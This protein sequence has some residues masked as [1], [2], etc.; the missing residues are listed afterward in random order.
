M[1][2]D[3]G[4]NEECFR[5]QDGCKEKPLYIHFSFDNWKP[6]P[7]VWDEICSMWTLYRMCPPGKN[8]YYFSF[9]AEEPFVSSDERL[10]GST[11][12]GSHFSKDFIRPPLSSLNYRDVR[13]RKGPLPSPLPHAES[14]LVSGS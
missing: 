9:L 1:W 5:S 11:V 14:C 2:I 3:G 7:M 13:R 8:E 4:W 10:H 12:V 6:D